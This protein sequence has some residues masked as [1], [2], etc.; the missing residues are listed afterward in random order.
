MNETEKNSMVFQMNSQGAASGIKIKEQLGEICDN[1]RKATEELLKKIMQDNART[2]Y[3][4]KYG[5]ENIRTL[6]DYRKAVPVITYDDIAED[7]ERMK[8]GEKNILTSYHFAHMNETSGTVGVKKAVP[9]TDEQS[10]VF[11]KYSNQLVLGILGE[12]LGEDWMHGRSYCTSQGNHVRLDSG[13]TLGCASSIM[14][15]ICKGGIEPYSSMLKSMYTS[16]PEAMSPY[17]GTDTVYIHTRFA[18]MDREITGMTSGFITQLC[19]HFHYIHDNYKML[20]E[21]IET[22]TINPAVEL[23][24]DVRQSLLQRITPMP[25]R[26]AELREAFRDGPDY[27]FIHNVWPKMQYFSCA[28]GDGFSV[29]DALFDKLYAG[30]V[31]HRVYSGITAS[32][33]MWSAPVALDD[34]SS[35]IIPDSA[36]ME[37]QPVEAEDDFS[38]IKEIDELEVGKT[39]E[40]IITN[41]CGFYRYR[42]SDAVKVVGFWHNTPLVQFMYRVNKTINLACEKTTET[43]LRIT[44]ENTANRLGFELFDY[45]VYPDP[46]AFPPKYIFMIEALEDVP[47]R[48]S[49]EALNK[50]VLEELCH[51]NEE[52][53]ECYECSEIQA[54]DCYFESPQT[55]FLYLDK[56]VFLGANAAQLKPVHVI[57]TEEQK[58]FFM[59]MRNLWE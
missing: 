12:S 10:Q 13:I 22:G 43:A 14:A 5:F 4:K 32:E 38:Q 23:P 20:I 26:G 57:S 54:P 33:G 24:D 52:F 17:P 1:P 9:L 30:G 47:G 15:E 39:Y 40:L 2:E 28:G 46:S 11:M 35:V 8:A 41:L 58:R 27:P 37:F 36:V 45:E 21:D 59:G 55:Q 50:V 19:T 49:Q 3:G 25:E 16:P 18:L 31:L 6:D 29:Y 42:M 7:I 53:L 56:M 51:A 44:A 48:V 34:V